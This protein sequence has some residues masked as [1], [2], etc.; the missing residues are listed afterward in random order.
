MAVILGRER[1][2]DVFYMKNPQKVWTLT[3]KLVIHRATS[4]ISMGY[5]KFKST[6]VNLTFDTVFMHELEPFL[7]MIFYVIY[8]SSA[9]MWSKRFAIL[10][11]LTYYAYNFLVPL[12]SFR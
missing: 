7:T 12:T 11:I 4:H 2:L 10:P 6:N 9:G 5:P 3:P 1:A 8:S